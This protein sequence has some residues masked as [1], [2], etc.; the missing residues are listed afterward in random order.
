MPVSKGCGVI[1][2]QLSAISTLRELHYRPSLV[3]YHLRAQG[4]SQTF[5]WQHLKRTFCPAA[6]GWMVLKTQLWAP[7]RTESNR[8]EGE[9]WTLRPAILPARTLSEASECMCL[10]TLN[11]RF[12][13][14]L[15]LR[16]APPPLVR[17]EE[18]LWDGGLVK[19]PVGGSCLGGDSVFHAQHLPHL[20]CCLG[21]NN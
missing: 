1:W 15:W 19:G 17:E 5:P 2:L 4:E 18:L 21:T 10:R 8:V 11:P 3:S 14:T 16:G 12:P 9:G 13:S 6:R 7:R 20:P